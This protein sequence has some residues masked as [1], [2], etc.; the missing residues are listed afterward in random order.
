MNPIMQSV[1]RPMCKSIAWRQSTHP[2]PAATT[3][4]LAQIV[5]VDADLR[6]HAS[7][8]QSRISPPRR[9]PRWV[10]W[11][12]KPVVPSLQQP[13]RE[14]SLEAVRR[15]GGSIAG[16]RITM[17]TEGTSRLSRDVGSPRRPEAYCTFCSRKTPHIHER[18]AVNGQLT[19]RAICLAC[20][21]ERPKQ[22]RD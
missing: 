5:A 19:S 14:G 21:N 16:G 10:R 8:N 13:D 18:L 2:N 11:R 22:P 4:Q 7:C 6:G 20:N 17:S 15:N 1:R 12:T 3:P 9:E